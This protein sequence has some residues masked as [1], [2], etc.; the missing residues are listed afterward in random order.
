MRVESSKVNVE[1]MQEEREGSGVGEGKGPR[2]QQ[3]NVCEVLFSSPIGNPEEG[4][5]DGDPSLQSA[6]RPG[7][8]FL[9]GSGEVGCGKRYRKSRLGPRGKVG[10]SSSNK[11]SDLSPGSQRPNKRVRSASNEYPPGF[12]FIGFTSRV[13]VAPGGGAGWSIGPRGRRRSTEESSPD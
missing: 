2:D 11:E 7:F 10:L 8:N 1:S 4:N 3:R 5:G 6:D 12:G 9:V 13:G